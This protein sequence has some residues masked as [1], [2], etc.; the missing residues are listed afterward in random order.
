MT[1]FVSTVEKTDR[2]GGRRQARIQ[3]DRLR[4]QLA[5]WPETWQHCWSTAGFWAQHSISTQ[6]GGKSE[7]ERV[8]YS[9][10]E[11]GERREEI[12]RR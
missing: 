4:K 9:T 8:Q 5:A 1:F 10:P 7:E 11:G 2:P 12:S 6:Y 3:A